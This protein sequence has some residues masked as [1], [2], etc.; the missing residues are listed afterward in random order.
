M[1]K[2]NEII[3]I[4]VVAIILALAFS[5]RNFSTKVFSYTMLAIIF[6]LGINIAAK[7]IASYYLDSEIEM[8]F[9]EIQRFGFKPHRHLK[10]PFP[11]G[12]FLP[13]ITAAFSLGYFV[14][15]ACFTFEVNAK[16]YRAAKR[17]GLY[18]FSEMTESHIGLIAAS[19]I[20]ANLVFAA[21]G[22][23]AGW[24]LFVKLSIYYVFFNMLPISDLDGNKIL[25]GEIILWSFLA[26]LTL[27]ALAYAFWVV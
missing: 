19:G 15:M 27:L 11:A 10:K 17:H 5:V 2:R 6:I 22:Y 21:I 18:S 1:I 9:W 26:S 16:T 3:A 13:I 4:V 7:K 14:W 12:V 24:D 8:K 23:F 20:L 25:F